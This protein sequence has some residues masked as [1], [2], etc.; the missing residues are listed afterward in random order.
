MRGGW[1]RRAMAVARDAIFP[2][3]DGALDGMRAHLMARGLS[4]APRS[5]VIVA[6]L[7]PHLRLANV[8]AG[9][10]ATEAARSQARLFRCGNGI[11]SGPQQFTVV[12]TM[13]DLV[14]GEPGHATLDAVCRAVWRVTGGLIACGGDSFDI[15]LDDAEYELTYMMPLDVQERVQLLD[16]ARNARERRRIG[17]F[18]FIATMLDE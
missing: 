5:D 9:G 18:T 4:P 7:P 8:P 1:L 14:N 13:D 2:G 15:W 11:P 10:P 16:L 12:V 6:D 3:W 17:P